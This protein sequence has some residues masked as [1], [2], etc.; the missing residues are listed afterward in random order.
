MKLAISNIAFEQK[1][2]EFIY[3]KLAELG[4]D[5]LEIA[6]TRI[7]PEKPY[8]RLEEAKAFADEIKEKYGLKVVSMQSIW[9]GISEKIF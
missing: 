7:I 3:E 8:D 1:D 4:F 2:D 9:F 5:G 6:P